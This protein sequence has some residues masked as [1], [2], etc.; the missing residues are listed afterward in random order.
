[1]LDKI[2]LDLR[3]LNYNF[4]KEIGY[5]SFGLVCHI[6]DE[7][8]RD[9][10]VKCV[11]KSDSAS[12]RY[13]ESITKGFIGRRHANIVAVEKVFRGT[14]IPMQCRRTVEIFTLSWSTVTQV[15]WTTTDG[16]LVLG[17]L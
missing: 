8:Q 16:I 5:G 4:I 15:I 9:K 3:S 2:V 11:P 6:K 1:M 13:E 10:A 12:Q 14:S 7:Q 17:S